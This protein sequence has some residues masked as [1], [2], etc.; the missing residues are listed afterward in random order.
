M[1]D[2]YGNPLNGFACHLS[3]LIHDDPPDG[4]VLVVTN[5]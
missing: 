2:M 3:A 5:R 1:A 4:Q